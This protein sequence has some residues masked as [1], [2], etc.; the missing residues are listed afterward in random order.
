MP[1]YR[2]Q[3]KEETGLHVLVLAQNM[4]DEVYKLSHKRVTTINEQG[5]STKEALFSKRVYWDSVQPLLRLCDDFLDMIREANVLPT[6]MPETMAIRRVRVYEALGAAKQIAGRV[7][8]IQ[9]RNNILED[10]FNGWA[11]SYN[12][13]YPALQAWVS[14]HRSDYKEKKKK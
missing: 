9:R 12:I 14:S 6:D 4:T 8:D 7:N 5:V 11:R 1:D 2:K 13:M 10:H 3:P